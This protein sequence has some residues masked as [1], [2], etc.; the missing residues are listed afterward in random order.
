MHNKLFIERTHH[1]LSLGKLR[2]MWEDDIKLDFKKTDI[3]DTE[4][5]DGTKNEL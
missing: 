5:M 2:Q 1:M 4:L 3:F